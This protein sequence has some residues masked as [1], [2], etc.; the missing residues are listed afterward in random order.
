MALASEMDNYMYLDEFN[1]LSKKPMNLV[2][3]R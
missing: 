2:L 3:F 1:N